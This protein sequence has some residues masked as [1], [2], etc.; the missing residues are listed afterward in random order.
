MRTGVGPVNFRGVA[1]RF[2]MLLER[3]DARYNPLHR[4]V[5]CVICEVLELPTL[6]EEHLPFFCSD[7]RGVI[8]ELFCQIP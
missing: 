2:K 5:S 1:Q 6:T 3:G 7:C 8:E 4:P